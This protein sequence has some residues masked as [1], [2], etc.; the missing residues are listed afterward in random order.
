[1]AWTMRLTVGVCTWNR[2]A[3]LRQTLEQMTKL[4][5]PSEVDWELLIV[6]NNCTDATDEVIARYSKVLPI[7]RLFESKPGKSNALNLAVRET[8][9]EYI[10]WTDDDVLVDEGWLVEYCRAF[11]QWPDAAVFGGP[12]EPWFPNTPPRWLQQAWPRVAHAYAAR[13]FGDQPVRFTEHLVPFG[14]NFAV[15]ACVQSRYPYDPRLGPRPNSSLRGEETTCIRRILADGAEGW[16]VPAA[17]L[18][19]FIP[20]ERQTKRYLRRYYFGYGQYLARESPRA[21]GR[22]LFGKP[23][24]V[25]KQAVVAELR[26]RLYRPLRPP[27][28]W[29][30]DLKRASIC[31]GRIVG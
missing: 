23:R 24:W 3:L 9:G 17:R 10:L 16:W 2:A 20:E 25:W 7:R 15:R 29:I 21:R 4:A 13:N 26:Y 6:N 11:T 30:E 14:V 31:W 27:E 12:V 1:M 18:R 22:K 28:V 5:I 19:H 8:R